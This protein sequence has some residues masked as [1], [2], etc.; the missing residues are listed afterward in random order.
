MNTKIIA[1]KPR[2]LVALLRVE[3][4]VEILAFVAVIM[5]CTWMAIAHRWL[6]LGEFPDFFLL[7]YMI[8]SVSLLYGLH[9]GLLWLASMD[10]RRFRPLIIYLAASYL[11][12]A[13]VFTAVDVA[14]GMPWW[15]TRSEVGSV[16]CFSAVLFWLL[17]PF[18]R[19]EHSSAPQ[20]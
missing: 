11:L 20:P 16:L 9:G 10:V 7:D 14:D 2:I 5:P 3:G 13:F 17:G 1:A 4:T 8:R 18:D 6:G 19:R 15:W 12:A